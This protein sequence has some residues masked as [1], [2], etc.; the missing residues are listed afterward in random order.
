MALAWALAGAIVSVPYLVAAVDPPPGRAF[1]G[2]FHWI[3][4]LYNYASFVQQA[5]DGRVLFRNKLVLEEHDATLVNV[6]GLKQ[7]TRLTI[8][9][10]AASDASLDVLTG[11]Q[12]LNWL[13]IKETRITQAGLARLQTALPKCKILWSD[14]TPAP[15]SGAQVDRATPL[16]AAVP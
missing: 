4:D 10:T 9:R 7:L 13:E 8:N 6:R 16:P 1:A 5:E 15:N 2:T 12:T 11:L 14:G 3:D